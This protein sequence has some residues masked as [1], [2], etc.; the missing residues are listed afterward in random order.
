MYPCRRR[1][2]TH[3]HTLWQIPTYPPLFQILLICNPWHPSWPRPGGFSGHST[4]WIIRPTK[5]HLSF[6]GSGF[7]FRNS[8]SRTSGCFFFSWWGG[9]HGL[10]MMVDS[11]SDLALRQSATRNIHLERQS[12]FW[13]RFRL[14]GCCNIATVSFDTSRQSATC[15]LTLWLV[16]LWRPR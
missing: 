4:S 6:L 1:A 10:V 11:I 2:H 16:E 3:T 5:A 12:L 13:N 8:R 15:E 14:I 9:P 7:G